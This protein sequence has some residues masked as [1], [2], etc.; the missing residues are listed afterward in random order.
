MS[1]AW[2]WV[3][4]RRYEVSLRSSLERQHRSTKN[5]NKRRQVPRRRLKAP[6]HVAPSQAKEAQAQA[7][8]AGV[9]LWTGRRSP[10]GFSPDTDMAESASIHFED[11]MTLQLL[12]YE[13]LQ[14]ADEIL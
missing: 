5:T 10:Q 13:T 7:L 1:D 14:M 3:E 6:V 8:T 11:S 2:D 9:T 12:P 4:Q